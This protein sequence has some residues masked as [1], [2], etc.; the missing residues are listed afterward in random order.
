MRAHDDGD[1]IRSGAWYAAALNRRPVVEDDAAKARRLLAV[2]RFLTRLKDSDSEEQLLSTAVQAAA[3]W[4]DV[5]ALAYRLDVAGRFVLDTHLPGADIS[6]RPP[7]LPGSITPPASGVPKLLSSIVEIEELGWRETTGEI[8]LNSV[9]YAGC[10]RWVIVTGGRCSDEGITAFAAVGQALGAVL[11]RVVD[12][13]AREICEQLN[14]LPG[15]MNTLDGL[16]SSARD[17]LVK[18]TMAEAVRLRVRSTEMRAEDPDEETVAPG[19]DRVHRVVPLPAR[20]ALAMTVDSRAGAP[21]RPATLAVI[22]AVVAYLQQRV[23][24]IAIGPSATSAFE[25]RVDEAIAQARRSGRGLGLALVTMPESAATPNPAPAVVEVIRSG[26]R[27]RDLVGSLSTREVAVVLVD[28]GLDGA[29]VA[30]DRIRLRLQS[31]AGGEESP[32]VAIWRGTLAADDRSAAVL[33]SETRTQQSVLPNT[34][35]RIG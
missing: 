5:E 8:V 22:D 1:A 4:Y 24:A 29:L 30:G 3:V 20:R 33:F 11:Q 14:Q 26:L 28:T 15:D 10:P 27:G 21:F 35:Q 32:Q 19:V 6:N 17:L 16:L 12:R 7:E 2:L 18:S 25:A 34:S 13:E 31:L 23:G 9:V